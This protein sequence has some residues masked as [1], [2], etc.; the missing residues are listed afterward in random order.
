[1]E[2]NFFADPLFACLLKIFL[3]VIVPKGFKKAMHKQI[4]QNAKPCLFE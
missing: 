3:S 2:K 1:M 4:S